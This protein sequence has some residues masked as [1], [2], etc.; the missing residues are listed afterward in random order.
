MVLTGKKL[1]EVGRALYGDIWVSVLSRRLACAKRTV[2][3]W[4]S[5]DTALPVDLRQSLVDLIDEQFAVLA[6]KR[7]YLLAPMDD[8]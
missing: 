8:F 1:E 7:D 6:E 4:R 3:R 2:M 5:E